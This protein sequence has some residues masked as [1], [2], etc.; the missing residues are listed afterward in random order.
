MDFQEEL[1]IHA[2]SLLRN[3]RVAATSSLVITQNTY[4]HRSYTH[5]QVK[6]VHNLAA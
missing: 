3:S 1:I 6:E 5:Y 2:P 4:L